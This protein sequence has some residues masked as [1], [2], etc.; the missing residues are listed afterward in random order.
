METT[1]VVETRSA[2]AWQVDALTKFYLLVYLSVLE[3]LEDY[4]PRWL[5]D[6]GI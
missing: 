2:R 1:T 4:Y 6:L 5:S 3:D